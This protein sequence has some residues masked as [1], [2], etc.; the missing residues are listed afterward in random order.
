[1]KRVSGQ[2]ILVIWLIHLAATS[3]SRLWELSVRRNRTVREVSCKAE[4][5]PHEGI[6]CLKCPAGTYVKE[7]CTETL[8]DGTCEACDYDTYTEHENGLNQC[9]SCTKCP[10]DQVPS[11]TCTRTS[12]TECQCKEGYFCLPH[13]ACEVCKKCSKCKED[14]FENKRCT[15]ISN[16]I[17]EKK[18]ATNTTVVIVLVCVVL[19]ALLIGGIAFYFRKTWPHK[20]NAAM[21]RNNPHRRNVE[22]NVRVTEDRPVMKEATHRALKQLVGSRAAEDEDTGLGDSLP[23]TASSS[24]AS[25]SALTPSS[26]TPLSCSSSGNS[27]SAPPNPLTLPLIR[28]IDHAPGTRRL[29]PV[30]GEESLK[31]SF[32]LFEE[33]DVLF[34]KRF[35]RHIGLS[36]NDIRSVEHSCSDDKMYALLRMWMERKGMKACLNDLIDALLYLD[37]RLSAENIIA[38]A[39][40]SGLYTCEETL[41]DD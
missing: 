27:S 3:T 5:Y 25:L 6:C 33:V 32:D 22:E 30:N 20:L 37:Q 39:V 8:Q 26:H 14:E 28:V 31:K 29:V 7:H 34:H 10:P 9:L 2:I 19:P 15:P 4:A 41:I 40:E 16:T 21:R 12:N 18:T 17:C 23:N 35:F 36:D 1:M 11:K 24:Q 38:Q 13:H